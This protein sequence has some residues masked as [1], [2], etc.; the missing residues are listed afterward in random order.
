V[1]RPY[2]VRRGDTATGLA[3]R[4]HAWT[5]ELMALNHL[6]RH[7]RLYVGQRLR[8]PVVVA[9]APKA[10]HH[11]AHR[12][13]AHRHRAHRHHAHRH[14]AHRQPGHHRS[15]RAKHHRQ[16]A[17]RH[18]WRHAHASRGTV[19][20]VV[21][22]AAW[23]HGVPHRLALAVAWQESGWQQRR[24]SSAGA[25]GVM[26]V[27]PATGRWMS[28]LAGHR[29]H[30]RR[31]HQ[32]VTAGVLLMRTLR[33]QAHERRAIAGYYQGLA[34]VRRHGMYPSTRRYVANVVAIR[35]RLR[36]GWDPV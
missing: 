11:R 25:I 16:A 15:H 7:S 36:H 2:T 14:H 35:N 29:L 22:R 18:G 5:D 3:V 27:M 19:R 4:F 33:S 23:R 28:L 30:L 21:T 8:I 26:Q 9:S 34:S 12:H 1:I 6:S 31:L 20:R 32:N 17:H 24:V 10:R 13:H